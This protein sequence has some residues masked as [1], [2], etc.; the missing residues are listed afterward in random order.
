MFSTARCS[1]AKKQNTSFERSGEN[2]II[3]I[4]STPLYSQYKTG[5]IH[6]EEYV[7]VEEIN[8][9]LNKDG[10]D[11]CIIIMK[12]IDK[13]NIVD[14]EVSG[15]VDR[16]RRGILVLL[17]DKKNYKYVLRNYDCFSSENEDGGVYFAPELS[18]SIE[19]GNV[20]VHYSHGRY[21]AWW[22][23]FKLRNSDLE[24]IGYDA[25]DSRGPVTNRITSINFLTKKKQTQININEN[26]EGD[27]EIFKEIWEDI[28][29][30][31][32][33]KLSEIKDFG[34]LTF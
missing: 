14:V 23:T 1:K 17:K 7:D 10:V 5:F 12:G 29:I 24:L 15:K 6:H 31:Q 16:N 3:P 22:Y 26:A 33:I 20:V 32:T 8:G 9:D 4:D 11:D 27:D 25:H 30:K 34:S 2:T 19:K 28:K 13:N 21:G 18:I